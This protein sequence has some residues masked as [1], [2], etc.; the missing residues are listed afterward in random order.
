MG[1][2]DRIKDEMYVDT[3]SLL[4]EQF[5]RAKELY[6]IYEDNTIALAD[7]VEE[8]DPTERIL[9]RLV[10]QHYI[11][12]ADDEEAAAL[13]YD[14]FYE[15]IDKGDSTVRNYFSDLV[16]EGLVVKAEEQG[17][18]EL[19]VERLGDAIDRI[20]EALASNGS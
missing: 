15:R 19:V 20:E 8:L 3:E 13:S 6:D 14:Y 10:A 17:E 7:D 5:E 16:G 9:T 1:L 12:E 18:H 2:E 11:A 4:E